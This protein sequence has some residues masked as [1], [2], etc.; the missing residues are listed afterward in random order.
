MD[1]SQFTNSWPDHGGSGG[2]TRTERNG[3]YLERWTRNDMRFWAVSDLNRPEFEG[4]VR[5]L[6]ELDAPAPS[7]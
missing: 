5:L 6:Q 1:R 7:P 2:A 3:Y 4:F